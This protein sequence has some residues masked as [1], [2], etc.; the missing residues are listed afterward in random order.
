MKGDRDGMIIKRKWEMHKEAS[1]LGGVCICVCVY[2]CVCVHAHVCA[3]VFQRLL[4]NRNLGKAASPMP[5]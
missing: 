3:C 5:F 4:M 1:Y 2:V